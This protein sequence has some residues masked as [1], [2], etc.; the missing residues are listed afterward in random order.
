MSSSLTYNQNSSQ[1]HQLTNV[2]KSINN[3]RA[4]K[5]AAD[6]KQIILELSKNFCSVELK[7]S[8]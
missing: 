3:T 2:S 1:Q 4:N 5:L 7:L 6:Y 8:F